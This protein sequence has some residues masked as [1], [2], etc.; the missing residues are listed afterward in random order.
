MKQVKCYKVDK[1]KT[2]YCFHC[3]A[4]VY[5]TTRM[6]PIDFPYDNKMV[7]KHYYTCYKCMLSSLKTIDKNLAASYSKKGYKRHQ[8]GDKIYIKTCGARLVEDK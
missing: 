5:E 6:T 7:R 3:G 8:V 1:N 2:Y 4:H